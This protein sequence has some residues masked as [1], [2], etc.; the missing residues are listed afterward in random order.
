MNHLGRTLVHSQM[1]ES[2]RN[3]EAPKEG[4][5][6]LE[7]EPDLSARKQTRR[8][9]AYNI[10]RMPTK[11]SF[12]WSTTMRFERKIMRLQRRS[13]LISP[14]HHLAIKSSKVGVGKY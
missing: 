7:P 1:G 5:P 3:Q 4:N 9:T 14:C 2:Q 12:G 13:I 11:G 10:G 8:Y 6:T